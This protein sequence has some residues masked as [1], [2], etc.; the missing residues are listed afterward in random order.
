MDDSKWTL[1]KTNNTP[2]YTAARDIVKTFEAVRTIPNDVR[3]RI[4]ASSLTKHSADLLT[5][6]R[7][8]LVDATDAGYHRLEEMA[9]RAKF[10]ANKSMID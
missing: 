4:Q 1:T 8:V 2:P 9:R 5:G 10:T 7:T 6:L 3:T